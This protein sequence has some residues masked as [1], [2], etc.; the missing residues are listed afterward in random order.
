MPREW[1]RI[2]LNVIQ[3]A[4]T[5]GLAVARKAWPA[6]WRGQL[7][8]LIGLAVAAFAAQ[9]CVQFARRRKSIERFLDKFHARAWP[10][11]GGRDPEYRVRL[12]T[13]KKARRRLACYYRTDGHTCS[14]SWGTKPPVG[15]DGDGLVGYIWQHGLDPNVRA[16]QAVPTEAEVKEYQRQTHIAP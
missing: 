10:K 11:N 16:L 7:P 12:F 6:N 8:T 4:C 13:V 2:T 9:F 1:L 3:G 15:K 5:L 14:R